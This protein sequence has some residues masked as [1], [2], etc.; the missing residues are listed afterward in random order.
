M[1]KPVSP[2]PNQ[3]TLPDSQL[4][5]KLEQSL[6]PFADRGGISCARAHQLA[7]GLKVSPLTV[8]E[9]LDRLGIKIRQCQLGLFGHEPESRIVPEGVHV[10]PRLKEAITSRQRDSRLSCLEAWNLAAEFGLSRLDICG[11]C[12]KLSIR[13]SRCQLGAF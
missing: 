6:A 4:G 9:A 3:P 7:T 10:P 12:E 2:D 11:A 5:Q 1:P 13:I 8:G